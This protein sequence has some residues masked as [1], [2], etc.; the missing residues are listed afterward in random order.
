[1]CGVELLESVPF[2]SKVSEVLPLFVITEDMVTGVPVGQKDIAV[3][4]NR[5]GGRIEF[6]EP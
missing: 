2:G 4:S 3:G 6:V 5:N 1:M